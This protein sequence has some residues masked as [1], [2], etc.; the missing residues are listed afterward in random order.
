MRTYYILSLQFGSTRQYVSH[1]LEGTVI[2][3]LYGGR[4]YELDGDCYRFATRGSALRAFYHAVRADHGRDLR[5][6][7][8]RTVP[9]PTPLELEL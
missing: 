7:V 6:D 2:P 5:I 9:T 8:V 3:S 1:V 4:D